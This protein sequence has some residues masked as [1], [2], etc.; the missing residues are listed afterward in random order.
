MPDLGLQLYERGQEKPTRIV[1]MPLTSLQF[2]LKFLPMN[3]KR[4]LDQE[5]INLMPCQELI[6]EKELRGTLIE[7]ANSNETLVISIS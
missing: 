2:S 1:T 3:L 4:L 7:I 5:G 6:K